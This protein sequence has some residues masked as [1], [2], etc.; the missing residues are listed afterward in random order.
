MRRPHENQVA[1]VCFGCDKRL[2]EMLRVPV[3]PE[4]YV[5]VCRGQRTGWDAKPR[6][7]CL[8]RALVRMGRYCGVC[9]SALA[10]SDEE[11]TVCKECSSL[12]ETGRRALD[13]GAQ[14]YSLSRSRFYSVLDSF[15]HGDEVGIDEFLETLTRA[16][17]SRV[18]P[19]NTF[20][21]PAEPL[22]KDDGGSHN[23]ALL[24]KPEQAEAVDAFATL[25]VRALKQARAEGKAEGQSLVRGLAAGEMTVS[26]FNE[27][28]ETR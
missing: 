13:S 18:S 9:G 19:K 8:R 26:D 14:W 16:V 7:G 15:P 12:L 25:C 3:A 4:Q 10:Y 24:L 21:Q 27:G 5:E 28:K 17:S 2:K 20:D 1:G 6:A 23:P 22:S 11:T